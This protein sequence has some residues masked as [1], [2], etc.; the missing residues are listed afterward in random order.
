MAPLLALL[1]WASASAAPVA[2]LTPSAAAFI[3]VPR[4]GLP[5]AALSAASASLSPAFGAPLAPS[6]SAPSMAPLPPA[7]PAPWLAALGVPGPGVTA[8]HAESVQ[9]LADRTGLP[10][11]IHGSRQ[12]GVRHHDGAPFKPGTDLDLGIV[13]PPEAVFEHYNAVFDGEA[14][15]VP[16]AQH[17]PMWS[18]PTVEEAVGRGFLVFTPRRAL[19]HADD[20]ARLASPLATSRQLAKVHESPR[21]KGETVRFTVIGDAEPGRFWFSRALFGVPGVFQRLLRRADSARP[22]FILQLG[23]LVSRGVV[24]QFRG[25]FNGLLAMQLK[26]PF[27]T[28]IG[29]HDRH[30][31][32]GVTHDK[33][34]RRY[35][36]ATDW[37]LDRGDWRF[38]SVDSSAGRITADQLAWLER[39]LE[40]GKRLIVFTHVPPAPLAKFTDAGPL[41]GVGG[42]RTGAKA[43]MDLMSRRKVER[44]YMGHV[45]G[46]GVARHGGVTYVLSGGGGS[47]LYPSTALPKLHHAIDVEAGPEGVRETVVPL[48]GPSFPLPL[49][50]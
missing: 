47:P 29:N 28:I 36:G 30:K 32:H 49:P 5:A 37:V 40:P 18:V 24:S 27:L 38:V 25:L 50:D 46:L 13:G 34:F 12:S 8:A 22:D 10:W 14:P 42:F 43:F 23:D 2:R 7:A 35:W 21:A 48:D 11:F 39:V 41:K 16:D 45:H 44:V 33:L 15:R 3:A 20:V 4:V 6:L 1:C 19:A 26:T 9:T 17:G 31:P